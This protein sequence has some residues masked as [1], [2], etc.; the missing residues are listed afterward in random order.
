MEAIATLT[1][2]ADKDAYIADDIPDSN[3]G[4]GTGLNIGKGFKQ[5][6]TLLHF[7]L[8]PI[9]SSAS[10]SQG[11]LIL[12][13]ISDSNN[14]T[15]TIDVH[16]VTS[17]WGE[18]TATWNSPPTWDATVRGSL[19]A[20]QSLTTKTWAITSLIQDWVSGAAANHGCLMKHNS[21]SPNSFKTF[22]SRETAGTDSDPRVTVVYTTNSAPNAPTLDLP[23]NAA[24]IE[25]DLANTFQFDATDPDAGDSTSA[26]ALKIIIDGVT[27]YWRVSD[28]T[29][30]AAETYNAWVTTF[31]A[32]DKQ[33]VIPADAFYSFDADGAGT[34]SVSV[35]DTAGLASAYSATR[36]FTIRP[37]RIGPITNTLPG[38][39]QLAEGGV[40]ASGP[41]TSPLPALTQAVAGNTVGGPITS[42]LS[43]LSQSA[44]GNTIGGPI[45]QTLPVLQSVIEGPIFISGGP[46]TT[47]R[48]ITFR[49]ELLNP[50]NTHKAWLE[51]LVEECSVANN[52]LAEIKR[53]ARLKILDTTS[54]NWASD[55]IKPHVILNDVDY[56]QGVFLL[57]SPT[58]KDDGRVVMRDIEAYDQL[59]VLKDDKVDDRYVVAAAANYI[60]AVATV[61][62]GAGITTS[63]LTPTTRT[64]PAAREWEPG[65]TKLQ[66]VNDLLAAIN[67]RSLYFDANGVAVAEPY[68]SPVVL[69]PLHTYRDGVDSVI[70]HEVTEELDLFDVP[71]KW[72]LYTSEPDQTSLRS[73]YTNT[74]ATS[75]T[76]TVSRGRTIP[77][78]RQ[79]EAADQATLD[80]LASRLA[81]EASQVFTAMT[82]D[83]AIMPDHGEADVVQFD[84]SRL[85][86]SGKF[87]EHEW[88]F[89]FKPGARM[90]HRIRRVVTV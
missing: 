46:P 60:A 55:R 83:T 1:V 7:D 40:E 27:R 31:P 35:K 28:N 23:V 62:T 4:G 48:H 24:T 32:A 80:A 89:Q 9:P 67:Y 11:D 56:P 81:F 72:V 18:L 13:H 21:T 87:S 41:I 22:A 39:T 12:Q 25:A 78:Y 65:T 42:P 59:Q 34:W 79:V 70:F 66:I 29:W 52:A 53:T 77:D 58:R 14:G 5:E 50:N 43:A 44:A 15:Q 54:I 19:A 71:N 85:G 63:N 57:S 51:K 69:P 36:T 61:L 74:A 68:L 86:V 88:G 38:L 76:S 17:T 20:D 82:F 26:F 84:F 30:Q 33:V 6:Y 47:D 2:Y 3:Q 73:V 37:S 8:S 49:Y 64:L 45:A 10:V 90:K 16:R 75:P